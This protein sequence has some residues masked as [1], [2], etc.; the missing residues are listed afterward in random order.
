MPKLGFWWWVGAY[1]AVC[2]S[3]EMWLNWLFVL[4]Y[5]LMLGT[6]LQRGFFDPWLLVK[7]ALLLVVMALVFG[8]MGVVGAM[9][10]LRGHN[11][12]S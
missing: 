3:R 4:F 7:Q 2:F 6:H 10:K 9:I 1:F 12:P 11:G 8:A 5:V